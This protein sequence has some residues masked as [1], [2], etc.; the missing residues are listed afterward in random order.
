MHRLILTVVA[1]VAYVAAFAQTES[2]QQGDAAEP[3]PNIVE[4]ITATGG[5]VIVQ[6]SS[7][8]DLLIFDTKPE[9]KE[10]TRVAGIGYRVQVFSDN[11]ARTA[12]NEARSKSRMVAARFPQYHTYVGYTTP[13]WRLRVGDF[14]N[15]ADAAAAAEELKR[16]FPQFR[17]E[18]HVVQ[19]RINP[20][21]AKQ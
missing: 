16:A 20:N 17:T 21:A 2:P 13:Y 14:K 12:K 6:P 8:A 18:I 9:E 4:H 1:L 15:K 10:K 3:R 19:D 11:N 7:L 5:N